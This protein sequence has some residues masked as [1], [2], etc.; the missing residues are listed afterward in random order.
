MRR[1]YRDY[2]GGA[3]PKAIAHALNK[4][5]VAG[6]RGGTWSPSAI[7]GD[8]RAGDGI[9]CQE[10]YVGVRV[11]NRRKFR[12]HPETGR[13][14]SILNPESEWLREPV[15]HLR[16]LDDDLWN[17]VR[18]RQKALSSQPAAHA[19]RPKR[20]LSGLMRCGVCGGAMTLN[21]AKYACSSHRER[22][23]CANNK[24]IAAQTVERR[25]IEGVRTR[26]LS[27]EAIAEAVRRHREAA[28]AER[29]EVLAS[30]APIER[31]LAEIAR[32][33]ERAQ[34]LCLNEAMSIQD[35]KALKAK[36]AARQAELEG[37]LAS[38]EQPT[39]VA[40]HP[41]AAQ[42]YARLAARLHEVMEGDEGEEVRAELRKLSNPPV[43]TA[44]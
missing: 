12:K 5:G 19:R 21:G 24:I 7:A 30:R 11:F 26:L 32:R 28:A 33:L 13:R 41:G 6:P 8:R 25:V 34:E 23:T 15:P 4:A 35:L 40:V 2:A 36:H 31:E 44:L 43:S 42:A 14:S 22:G 29:R 3:S 37:K 9:L 17:A 16:I 38:L 20:L 1:I 39:E 10:L 27:P 18:A